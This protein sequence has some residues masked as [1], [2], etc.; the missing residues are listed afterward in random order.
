MFPNYNFRKANLHELYADLES[1]DWSVLNDTH[2][3]DLAVDAFYK[4]LYKTIDKHVPKK[5][6]PLGSYPPWFNKILFFL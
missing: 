4:T 2:D 3:V 5:R 6:S 1:V